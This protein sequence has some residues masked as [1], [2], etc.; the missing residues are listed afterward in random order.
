MRPSSKSFQSDRAPE[1]QISMNPPGR[2]RIGALAS[3]IALLG[4]F[5]SLEAHAVALGRITVQSALG[6]S[7]RAEIDISDLSTDEASSLKVG[8]ADADVFRAAGTVRGAGRMFGVELSGLAGRS[9]RA[10]VSREN[11]GADATNGALLFFSLGGSN[12]I[13]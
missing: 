4:C 9:E 8:V 5:A 6:E 1:A 10:T 11:M 3:A 12:S 13:V 7:L 2:W